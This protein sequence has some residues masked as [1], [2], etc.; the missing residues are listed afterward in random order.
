MRPARASS[1]QPDQ[2]RGASR[3]IVLHRHLRR[4]RRPTWLS[5]GAR[6]A[7][8]SRVGWRPRVLVVE[9]Q[10][11]Q[12]VR[13]RRSGPQSGGDKRRFRDLLAWR[14][15]QR[16]GGCAR[17]GSTRTGSWAQNG[18]QQLTKRFAATKRI[19]R[20]WAALEIVDVRSPQARS[21]GRTG[22][23]A[24]R[25]GGRRFRLTLGAVYPRL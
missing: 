21:D 16:R 19:R 18:S 5:A 6:P 7:I 3:A 22:C 11:Q 1:K 14:P 12:P 24:R 17:Q 4:P 13:R 23:I 9:P 20:H 15:P 25:R 10:G 2:R 8:H